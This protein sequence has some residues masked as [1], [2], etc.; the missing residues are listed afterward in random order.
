MSRGKTPSAHKRLLDTA[1]GHWEVMLA[2]VR[3]EISK[4][5]QR[6]WTS[7]NRNGRLRK[8]WSMGSR[9]P[10]SSCVPQ[11]RIGALPGYAPVFDDRVKQ[12]V[13]HCAMDG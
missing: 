1:G 7:S 3:V 9:F 12:T 10:R 11:P 13:T 2:D 4:L 5:K 6:L 8:R